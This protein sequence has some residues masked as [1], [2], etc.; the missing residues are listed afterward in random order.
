M[1]S[2]RALAICLLTSVAVA[3]QPLLYTV[4]F[5]AKSDGYPRYRIPAI[6]WMPKKPLLAFCEGRHKAG[7]LTGDIDIVLRRSFDLGQTWQPLQIVA[8]LGADTCGNPCI[9]QDASNG[10]LWLAFTKSRGEDHEA[11]SQ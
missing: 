7:Q 11:D 3:Q 4:P 6:W 5:A 10:W 1:R 2:L 8:D 9:V